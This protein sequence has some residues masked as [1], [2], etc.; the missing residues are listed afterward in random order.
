MT[1]FLILGGRGFIGS[2]LCE[3]LSKIGHKVRVFTHSNSQSE[4]HINNLESIEI[5]KGDF[6]NSRDVEEAMDTCDVVFHLISS[7]LPNTSNKSPVYDIESNLVPTIN[8]LDL[9]VK[10]Q[11]KKIIFTSSGGTVYGIPSRIPINENSPTNPICSYGIT[12]L[13]IERYLYLYSYLYDLDYCV[14]RLANPYGK[15][16]KIISTQGVIAI[17]IH[18]MLCNKT[19]EVWGDGTII[20]DYVYIDDVVN[21]LITAIDYNGKEKVF[22]IGSGR[23]TSI[24]DLIA[25]M[26]KTYSRKVKVIYLDARPVD[27]P[28]NVLDINRAYHCLN[29]QP[30]TSLSEGLFIT[31]NYIFDKIRESQNFYG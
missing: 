20:R 2:H 6:L 10:H 21:A 17:F 9:A 3:R 12:K 13:A 7:T 26:E 18:K 22:N 30:L 31:I 28:T 4:L 5:F 23:G 16:Q 11:I 25:E 15:G 14:L 8:M 24:N 19:I 1:K 27:V 29:W